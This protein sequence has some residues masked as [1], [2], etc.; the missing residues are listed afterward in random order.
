MGEALDMMEMHLSAL[1]TRYA[2]L[3]ELEQKT[4]NEFR[5]NG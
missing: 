1:R 3:P 2:A 4:E 5:G